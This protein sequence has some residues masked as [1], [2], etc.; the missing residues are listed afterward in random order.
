LEVVNVTQVKTSNLKKPIT[1]LLVVLGV[2]AVLSL[3]A[4]E[5]THIHNGDKLVIADCETC[6][7]LSVSDSLLP[8]YFIN[9]LPET[10]QQFINYQSDCAARRILQ[11]QNARAPPVS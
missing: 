3:P 8:E 2:C 5:Q 6:L 4:L 1:L 7:Q 10:N 11:K 9:E